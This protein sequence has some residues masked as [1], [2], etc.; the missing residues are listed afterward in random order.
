MDIEIIKAKYLNDE[1]FSDEEL[2]LL[3][4]DFLNHV[5]TYGK[6]ESKK[7]LFYTID[8]FEII[9]DLLSESQID[10]NYLHAKIRKV[11]ITERNILEESSISTII[12]SIFLL[13][14]NVCLILI[15]PGFHGSLIAPLGI[16]AFCLSK[17]IK[18]HNL[19][20]KIETELN[21]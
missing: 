12:V 2:L 15:T 6:F 18:M 10:Y 14:M 21:L 9:K 17:G 7:K 13:V 1:I 19:V 3:S 16:L 4:E 20:K 11:T 5:L 8:N